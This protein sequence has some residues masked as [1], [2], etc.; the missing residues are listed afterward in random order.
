LSL[1]GPRRVERARPTSADTRRGQI[2]KG[3][4]LTQKSASKHAPPFGSG[5]AVG[6]PPFGPPLGP[7]HGGHGRGGHAEPFAFEGNADQSS[8]GTW[9]RSPGSGPAAVQANSRS[10]Q[11]AD[12][13]A[14]GRVASSL[15]E[16]LKAKESELNHLN[17]LLVKQAEEKRRIENHR[18]RLA[19]EN[20][21]LR[22]QVAELQTRQR[23][24]SA[25]SAGSRS[26]WHNGAHQQHANIHTIQEHRQPQLG[27]AQRPPRPVS[28][29]QHQVAQ[30]RDMPAHELVRRHPVFGQE[31]LLHRSTYAPTP[32]LAEMPDQVD[33]GPEKDF[34]RP[35]AFRTLRGAM[36]GGSAR[37]ASRMRPQSANAAVRQVTVRPG[38]GALRPGSARPRSSY[39]ER[40]MNA[41]ADDFARFHVQLPTEDVT[42]RVINILAFMRSAADKKYIRVG[43]FMAPFDKLKRGHISCTEFRR[44]LE[45]CGCFGDLSEEEYN[46]V[47]SFF[48]H[49][50]TASADVLSPMSRI[51]YTAFCEVLQPVGDKR[52]KLNVDQQV[53][54]EIGQKKG[55]VLQDSALATNELS[56]EGE[57][58]L[59]TLI[60]CVLDAIKKKGISVR[61]FLERLDP[62]GANGKGFCVSPNVNHSTGSL[63]RTQYLRVSAESVPACEA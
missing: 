2:A 16:V 57:T 45:S 27:G 28:A 46:L 21:N 23:P 19:A 43:D 7:T 53:L 63:S 41:D 50:S 38:S 58:K 13:P 62:R 14:R 26:P 1:P 10:P 52:V 22:G 49:E 60:Q 18:H 34:L 30:S 29:S 36:R 15:Q 54:K 11:R 31:S 4:T 24:W 47:F 9:E 59:K 42:Q 37:P 25:S 8:V 3:L 35:E 61:D 20:I 55:Q 32:S 51:S 39:A 17:S 56:A 5:P 6:G 12:D 33:S 44:A 40:L 48:M